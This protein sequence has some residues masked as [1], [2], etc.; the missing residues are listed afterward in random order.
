MSISHRKPKIL[1]ENVL[2]CLVDKILTQETHSLKIS[3]I[4]VSENVKISV[5]DSDNLPEDIWLQ[6]QG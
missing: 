3:V 1:R 2:F 6:S 4:N 5:P